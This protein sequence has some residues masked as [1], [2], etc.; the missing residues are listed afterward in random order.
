MAW[1]EGA[2]LKSGSVLYDLDSLSWVIVV[3]M[4]S[5][6]KIRKRAGA[7]TPFAKSCA[8]PTILSESLAQ[9]KAWGLEREVTGYASAHCGQIL[10]ATL[11]GC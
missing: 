5:R 2:D 8:F 4:K 11:I 7:T 1:V 6:S 9:A 10:A 3:K